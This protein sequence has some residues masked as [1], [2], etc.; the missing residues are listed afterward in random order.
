MEFC[1]RFAVPGEL[2]HDEPG[3]QG[4]RL[5]YS[6]SVPLGASGCTH[7]FEFQEE[8]VYRGKYS[9]C[10]QVLLLPLGVPPMPAL[11]ED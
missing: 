10:T 1:L 7:W 2:S 3:R 4:G 9:L 6:L 5:Q 8:I 11:T